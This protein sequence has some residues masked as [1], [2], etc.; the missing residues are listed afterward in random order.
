MS[1]SNRVPI[2]TVSTHAASRRGVI[3]SSPDYQR[4]DDDRQHLARLEHPDLVLQSSLS[5]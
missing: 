1:G 4:E 5:R 3:S 2:L